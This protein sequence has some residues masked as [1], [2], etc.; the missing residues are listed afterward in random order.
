M[1]FTGWKGYKSNN[2]YGARKV[3]YKGIDFD[4]KVEMQRYMYLEFQQKKGEISNLRRQVRFEIIPK[5]TKIIP[6]QLKTKIRYDERVVEMAAHYT[7]DFVYIEKGRYVMEDVKNA[8]SQDI[9][10]YPLR[11]KLMIR[12]I[13][14]HNTKG[15][16][17]WFFRESVLDGNRLKIKDIET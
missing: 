7:A 8:Y 12:K 2:K 1:A 17:I 16:G 9:R 6:N 3:S 14:Q 11:R 10:D 15:H 4:S 13:Q 5:T